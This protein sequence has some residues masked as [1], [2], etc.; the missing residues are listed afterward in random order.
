MDPAR[1]ADHAPDAASRARLLALDPSA[2]ADEPRDEIF[3]LSDCDRRRGDHRDAARR[4][5]AACAIDAAA[6]NRAGSG[7]R[8]ASARTNTNARAAASGRTT[9]RGVAAAERRA[10]GFARTDGAVAD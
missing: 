7:G 3:A 8:A 5:R 9:G 4:D 1:L 6:R 2:S 10:G